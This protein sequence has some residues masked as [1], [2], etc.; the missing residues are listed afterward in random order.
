MPTCSWPSRRRT[1]A[2]TERSCLRCDT[3]L[4]SAP[5]SWRPSA[6]SRRRR[7]PV[8]GVARSRSPSCRR[9]WEP[10]RCWPLGTTPRSVQPPSRW[11]R[12]TTCPFF[13]A[14]HGALTPFAPPLPRAA[15]LL[16]WSEADADFWTA[17]RQDV[18]VTAVGSQLL[19][20]AGGHASTRTLSST[21]GSPRLPRT[22]ACRRDLA[23]APGACRLDH[24]PAASRHLSTPPLGAR[25]HVASGASGV[26]PRRHHRRQPAACPSS[27][28]RRRSS[29]SSPPASSR[30]PPEAEMRGSTS[31][32]LLRGWASSGSVTACIDSAPRPRRAPAPPQQEPAQRIAEPSSATAAS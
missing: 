2:S 12:S 19:W 28:S 5:L 24:L 15:H 8:T 9:S 20:V 3:C 7:T 23:G 18:Q 10:A 26:R 14:Q 25:H 30:R 16:A 22:G 32:V 11:R 31:L 17:G 21:A 27:T 13:V 29:A 6:G 1:P 4:T